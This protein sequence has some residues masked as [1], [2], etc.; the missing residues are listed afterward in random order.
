M[1]SNYFTKP[2]AS[3]VLSWPRSHPR[4]PERIP[5]GPFQAISNNPWKSKFF[6]FWIIVCFEPMWE[7]VTIFPFQPQTFRCEIFVVLT[8]HFETTENSV[9]PIGIWSWKKNS[10]KFPLAQANRTQSRNKKQNKVTLKSSKMSC[11]KLLMLSFGRKNPWM[12]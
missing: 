7:G 4:M 11:L 5:W 1:L 3:D 10:K 9:Q 2:I 8:H 12:P 6:E